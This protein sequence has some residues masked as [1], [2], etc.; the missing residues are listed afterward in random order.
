M[1]N[2]AV[3]VLAVNA[4]GWG[5]A[6]IALGIAL[7]STIEAIVLVLVLR[8]EIPAFDPS[9]V[10]RVVVPVA[11]A[12]LAAAL[13]AFGAMGLLDGV[14][15]GLA[16]HVRALVQL[17][18]AGGLGALAYLGITSALRLPELGLIMRLMSDTLSRLRPA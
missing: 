2:V 1:I 15:A 12:S 7:G 14:T 4:L 8:R 17:V 3:G 11:L 10:V 18:V 13:V 9:P 5:L 16:L 6:G